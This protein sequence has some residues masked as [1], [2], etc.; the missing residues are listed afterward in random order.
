M[1]LFKHSFMQTG[2]DTAREKSSEAVLVH[3][4]SRILARKPR[5][6]T[7][8]ARPATT[9][10][11]SKPATWGF[12]LIESANPQRTTKLEHFQWDTSVFVPEYPLFGAL[13]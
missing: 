6:P 1:E 11:R 4:E 10:R 13:F 2:K 9:Y 5:Y 7:K 12:L 3:V 8:N